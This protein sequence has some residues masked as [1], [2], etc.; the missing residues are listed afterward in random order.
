MA[1]DYILIRKSRNALSTVLHAVFNVVL[2]VAAIFSVP[3]TSSWL[4]GFFLV[5]V[6]KWRTFAVRPRYLF[7]NIKSNLVDLF[8]GFSLVLLSFFSGITILPVHYLLAAFY[9]VWLVIIKPKTSSGWTFF[10][11]LAAVFLGTS[12]CAIF[13]ASLNSIVL[14]V[15]EFIIGYAAAR[16]VLAQNN[17]TMDY[18]FPA[19]IFG[20]TLAEISLLSYSWLIV[21]SFPVYGIM[22]PQ[23]AII[24]AVFSFMIGKVYSSIE[25]RDG[26]FR[27]KEVALPVLFSLAILAVIVIGFS[28]PIFNV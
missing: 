24:L 16:H 18:G 13:C 4:I 23:L 10:Q 22:I 2:G 11:A 3:L 25:S 5:L 8:V 7:L 21:Y 6:S 28:E 1:S 9:V 20:T 14:V 17:N 26:S 15:L 19:F 12:A 27:F